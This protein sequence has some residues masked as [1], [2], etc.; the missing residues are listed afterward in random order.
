MHTIQNFPDLLFS[1]VVMPV[2]SATYNDSELLGIPIYTFVTKCEDAKDSGS[3]HIQLKLL[4]C[5]D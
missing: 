3:D 1:L 4:K 2:V 5:Y